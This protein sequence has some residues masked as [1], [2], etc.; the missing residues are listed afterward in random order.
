MNKKYFLYIVAAVLACACSSDKPEECYIPKNTVEF[1]GNAFSSFSL[2]GD[3]KLHSVQ[4]PENTSEWTIQAVVPVRKEVATPIEDLTINLV[5]LDDRGVRVRD[6]LVLQGEDLQ[7]LLPVYNAGTNVERVIVFSIPDKEKKYLEHSDISQ[8]LEKTKGV[9]MDFNVPNPPE[10]AQEVAP[11]EPEEV[12]E[13][14][15]APAAKPVAKPAA[16]PVAKPEPPAPKDYPMTVD[17]LCRKYGVYGL[18]S[19]YESALR[20]RNK[21]GAKRIEDQLW[22]I[23]KR[24]KANNAIPERLRDSFVRYIEDKEDDIED[25]Y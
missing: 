20:N 18:L 24:V 10:M 3:V 15:P 23:E 22:A 9:R 14:T 16:K 8:L 2:G 21:S 4:N 17:G 19:Q 25:R 12:V 7:N 5:M 1:A 11:E 6:G 13:E